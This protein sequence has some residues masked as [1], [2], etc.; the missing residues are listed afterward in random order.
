MHFFY[1]SRKPRS[2]VWILGPIHTYPYSFEN[3]T[4][5]LRLQKNSRPLVAF[6]PVHTYAMNRF[7]N[8]DLPD[9]AR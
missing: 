4:C 6:S 2:Q 3:E 5:F 8:D 7:E 9:C 1:Y